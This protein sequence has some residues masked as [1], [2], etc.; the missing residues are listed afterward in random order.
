VAVPEAVAE[1]EVLATVVATVVVARVA[2]DIL[3][4]ALRQL[5][6]S[7]PVPVEV[8]VRL[9]HNGRP[10]PPRTKHPYPP[11]SKAA[12]RLRQRLLRRISRTGSQPPRRINRAGSQLPRRINR[13][14]SKPRM[15]MSIRVTIL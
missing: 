10:K 8:R 1:A 4:A 11:T 9:S 15:P 12:S 3:A 14:V 2:V 5:A 6:A 13:T 7:H